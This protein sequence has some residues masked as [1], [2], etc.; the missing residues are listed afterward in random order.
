MV[1]DIHNVRGVTADAIAAAHET[2]IHAQHKHGVD[3]VK[4]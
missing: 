2:D 1:M 3:C 4:Y